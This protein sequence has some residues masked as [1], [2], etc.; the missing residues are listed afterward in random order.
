MSPETID[1]HGFSPGCLPLLVGSLPLFV[2]FHP[3][4]LCVNSNNT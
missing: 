1:S 2:S 3:P 4:L